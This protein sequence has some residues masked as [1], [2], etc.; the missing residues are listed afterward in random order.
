MSE[1]P[2]EPVKA[3]G[4]RGPWLIGLAVVVVAAVL[5]VIA[6]PGFKPAGGDLKA[7][8]VGPMAKLQIPAAPRG[9]PAAAFVGPDGQ[10]VHLSDF[11]GQV[12]VV[13]F[14][15][16]WC[17]P[18]V[19]EMPTLAKLQA[20]YAGQ[21]VKVVAVSLDR[22]EDKAFAQRFIQKHGPL[23]FYQD[24]PFSVLSQLDPRPEG[25][26]VTVIIDGAGHE[27]AR[28]EGGAD[29]SSPQAKAVIDAVVATRS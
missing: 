10:S 6:G 21:P 28:L 12:L 15:A 24:A 23:Q 4:R 14:W 17:A 1:G 11:K 7:L 22:A 25:V 20:A 16:T 9:E 18:C 3:K 8:A 27:R 29:W 13:N 26:P 2:A 19:Q 5:Y